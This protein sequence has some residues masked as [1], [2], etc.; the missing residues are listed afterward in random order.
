MLGL[1][2][3]AN[4]ATH[5][6]CLKQATA[7]DSSAHASGARVMHYYNFEHAQSLESHLLCKIIQSRDTRS[8]RF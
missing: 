1:V 5:R 4:D 3:G 7:R 6:R 8:H 2:S